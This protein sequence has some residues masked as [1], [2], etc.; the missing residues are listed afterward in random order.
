MFSTLPA[1]VNLELESL[2]KMTINVPWAPKARKCES[3]V[4]AIS[5]RVIFFRNRICYLEPKSK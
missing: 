1:W 2:Y 5:R 4:K 3:K